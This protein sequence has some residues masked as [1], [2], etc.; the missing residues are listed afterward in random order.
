MLRFCSL[1]SVQITPFRIYSRLLLRRFTSTPTVEETYQRKSPREHI[2]LR[3]EVYVGS[4]LSDARRLWVWDVRYQRIVQREI[5]YIPALYKIF[6]EIIV[7]A[8]DN[9][10]RAA[11][12]QRSRKS[13]MTYIKVILDASKNFVSVE[14]DGAALPV[15]IHKDEKLYVPELVFGKLLTSSNYDDLQ[16]RFTGG[17]HGY[18]AKLTNIFSRK[19]TVEVFD[20]SR[21][22]EFHQQFMDNMGSRTQ[23]S[24]TKRSANE[25]EGSWTRISFQ[26]G[27]EGLLLEIE[28]KINGIPLS[29]ILKDLV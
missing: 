4:T 16:Q 10:Q 13:K 9:N 1:K 11:T 7:N 5:K 27:N 21:K 15:Q 3:P 29:Q 22:K 17:R 25:G 2:L 6:D 20:K 14:N 24:I 23:P 28:A 8:S 19:F 12:G 18:G 26:P